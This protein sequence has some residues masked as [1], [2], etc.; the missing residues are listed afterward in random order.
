MIKYL[1]IESV[2]KIAEN[3]LS[4]SLLNIINYIFPLLIIPILISRLGVENYGI[5]I[6]AYTVLNYL[7]L[8]VQ[9]GF[10]FS[11]TNKIAKNQNDVVLISDT[12]SSVS[13][14]RILISLSLIILL[15]LLYI[16]IPERISIYLYGIGIFLGQGLIPIWLFQGLEKMRFITIINLVVRILVFVLIYFFVQDV[17]DM[18]LLM[19][20]QSLSFIIGAFVSIIIVH[21]QLKVKFSFPSIDQIRRDLSEGWQLFLSTIGMNFYRESNIIILGLLTNYTTVGLYAPAEKLI[22]AIQSFANII[23]TAL[24]PYFSRRFA[25]E[26]T[27]VIES[28]QKVGRYLAVFFLFGSV[29]ICLLSY[30]IIELYLGEAIYNTVINLRILSFVI[31]LGGLNYYYGIIGLVNRGENKFFTKAVWLSGLSSIISC[32]FLVYFWGDIGAAIAMVLAELIL[33]LLVFRKIK[34]ISWG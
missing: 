13:I 11:A 28:F 15:G 34:I 16:F 3:F 9:Y 20:L 22:K 5:Y 1:K 27:T 4:L 19:G 8:L 2:R 25:Q 32:I 31:L 17:R 33:L 29:I 6:F 21:V 14:I 30:V 26:S 10:N 18:G 23:I 7:N 12:Y 24:Y